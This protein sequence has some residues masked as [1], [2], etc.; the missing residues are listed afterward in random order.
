[1]HFSTATLVFKNEDAKVKVKYGFLLYTENQIKGLIIQFYEFCM[2]L[3]YFY[4][5]LGNVKKQ[6]PA[7][8]L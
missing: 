3:E 5:T 7:L 1:L 6:I 2:I 8:L 4:R